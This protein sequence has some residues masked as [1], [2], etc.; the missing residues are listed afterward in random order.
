MNK[1]YRIIIAV[2]LVIVLIL[3][4]RATVGWAIKGS[5]KPPED[6]PVQVI[7]DQ[8][9]SA[10]LQSGKAQLDGLVW[11]D[12]DRDGLQDLGEGGVLNVT[13]NLY[14]SSNVLVG[15]TTTNANGAYRF[16]NLTPGDYY[17]I[18]F[19]PVDYSFS[20]QGQGENDLV[21]SDVDPNTAGAK[22]VMLV[23]GENNLVWTTGIYRLAGTD[24]QA[25][26]GTVK[27]PPPNIEVCIAG[28]N[29]LGGVVTLRVNRL[30]TDYCLSAYL[31]NHAFAIGR[32]PAGA[33]QV[34]AEVTFLEVYYQDRFVYAYDVSGETDSIQVCYAI[35]LGKQA[36]IYFLDFYGPRFGGRTGQPAWVP[37][38]TTV[39]NGIACAVTQ[40]SGAYAL[41]GK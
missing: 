27:P 9:A 25:A 4:A 35:P 28:V 18:V 26:G 38:P 30:T 19:P 15:S 5:E 32:I 12:Q 22:P 1:Y 8:P 6:Q 13:V 14:D 31:W 29:S 17:I 20:P 34:L 3:T 37:L 23:A 41:I 24:G 36:Q 10:Q 16:Q 33:G 11:N 7:Q 40:T 2:L 39:A 21:D